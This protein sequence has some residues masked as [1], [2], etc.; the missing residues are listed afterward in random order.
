MITTRK[1]MVSPH[2]S[3]VP[4][5][6]RSNATEPTHAVDVHLKL[7]TRVEGKMLPP[8]THALHAPAQGY[9]LDKN[10]IA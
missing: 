3:F 6:A 4:E 8:A 2:G 5:A 7:L 10:Y 1:G 9:T